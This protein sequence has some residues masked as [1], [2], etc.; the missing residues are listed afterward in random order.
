[1]KIRR[2]IVLNEPFPPSLEPVLQFDGHRAAGW[3]IGKRR[4]R[5]TLHRSGFLEFTMPAKQ[6]TPHWF[7]VGI[8]FLKRRSRGWS[9]VVTAHLG[10]RTYRV[11]WLAWKRWWPRS[12]EAAAWKTN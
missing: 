4:H 10:Q 1:M 12:S 8:E 5:Q 3:L 2:P 6:T 11:Q 7:Q 9:V